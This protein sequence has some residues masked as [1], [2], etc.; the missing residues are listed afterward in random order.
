MGR[1]GRVPHHND[2]V[3]DRLLTPSKISAW[4]DCDHYLTLVDEV[5]TGVRDPEQRHPGDLAQM[6]LDKGQQHE[7]QV[8]ARY[9]DEGRTVVEVPRRTQG[10]TFEQ[11]ARRVEPLL[12]A[13]HDVLYQMPF[14]HDGIRGVADFLE[15]VPRPSGAAAYEPV[16]A[17]LAR[18]EAKPAHVLQLCFYAEAIAARTGHTPE[19]LHLE[20]GSGAR[21]SIRLQ[22]VLPY[23]RRLRARLRTL[24]AGPPPT[25]TRPQP[26]EHC[27]FCEFEQVCQ[28]QWR[29]EDSLVHVAGLR[30]PERAAL[31]AADVTTIAALATLD[32]DVE[33]VRPQRRTTLTGQ[34]ALQVTARSLPDGAPP[35]FRILEPTQVPVPTDEDS[36]AVAAPLIGFAALPEPDEGDVFLDYEGHPFWRA[37]TGLFF[38][39]GLLE[40][41]EGQ[42]HYEAAWAHDQDGEREATTQL[43]R[44]LQRRRAYPSMHVYH[45]N[46]TERSALER[47]TRAYG[48]AELEL[49]RLTSIGVFV[50]L[51]PIVTT[52]IQ[53]GV[54]SHG[55]KQVERLTDFVRSHDIDRG[56]GAVVE[57]ERWMSDHDPARLARIARYNA[58]DVRATLALRDWLV[59]HRPADIPPRPVL[60]EPERKDADLDARIEALHAVGPGTPEHL[61]GDLL[62]YW[63]REG[64]HLAADCQRL[65]MASVADQLESPSAVAQLEFQGFADRF[66]A[67]TGAVL[68]QQAAVF[69]FPPQAV[70]ADI[71]PKSKMIVARRDGDW[72]FYTVEGIDRA[73]GTLRLLWN[74]EARKSGIPTS[75]V[76]YPR[77]DE[78]AKQ[79]ALT[80]LADRM[81]AGDATHV[82]HAVLR[83]DP[84]RFAP[85][86]GPA[87]G[88]LVGGHVEV[89]R[90]APHLDRSYLP[91][92]GPPGT[93]KT[94]TAAHLIAEQVQRGKRVG[95]TAMSHAAIDNV[96]R[97]TVA[98][99]AAQ[100][101]ELKAVRKAPRGPVKGVKYLDD[102]AG[103]ARGD[104]D[105]LGG[106]AWLFTNKAMRENPVDVLIVDEAGQLGLADTLAASI[107]ATSVVLLGDPQQ[108]PQVT[109]AVHPAGAGASALEHLLGEGVATFPPDRGLLLEV[110]RRMHPD[111]CR[112][113]SDTMYEG[114][115][116][117]DPSCAVQSTA[118]GTGLRWIP[119][120][121]AG[122]STESPEEATLVHATVRRL[123]GT[124]WTDRHGHS[125]V[126]GR[127]DVI[128]VT[129]YNDQRRLITQLLDADEDTAGVQVGTVDKFQGRE[130]VAVAFSMAASSADDLPRGVEFLFSRNRLNVAISR[131][132]C[133]AVMVCTER[134]LDTRAKNV[135]QMRLISALC[136]FVEQAERLSG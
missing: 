99:F 50:D 16:D 40:R 107:S 39:F 131:A 58:D 55:L 48:V 109:T 11:W 7:Q 43:V 53:I 85:G 56:A 78:S 57:Y 51:Y 120:E 88:R 4:L 46:H 2:D 14:V 98:H 25:A 112:F 42:W 52:A 13:G 91:I 66:H 47:L 35:P 81:L 124:P 100:G 101:M 21:E 123:L 74:D 129:A 33:G 22:D 114:R 80:H 134:L 73:A 15:Q 67:K 130:A 28:Q 29:D 54:E 95:V 86:H 111:V 122:R 94:F 5:E 9:R 105:V 71:A 103:C 6:L 92:Q 97:A 118:A 132:R 117:S 62:G 104:F 49:E 26:C 121:H 135:E 69:T 70:D 110:T 79:A 68:A 38:L 24:V 12:T 125:R 10:E 44:H 37:D 128:V 113:I 106:T 8:L 63:R 83:R 20:L 30:G 84:I 34:A 59:Q 31:E 60:L 41:R 75:L 19:H 32:G 18:A 65:S 72:A 89:C 116:T 115:L 126:I 108:L 3:S 93:G 64:Q 23:W 87:D 102:N 119:A 36:V 77:F 90:W 1:V 61:M 96:M 17:K 45:Y 27:P 133:L 127:D 76:H 136:S 82:A